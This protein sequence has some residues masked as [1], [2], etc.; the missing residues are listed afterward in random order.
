MND[1]RRRKCEMCRSNRPEPSTLT[2]PKSTTR[3]AKQRT[4]HGTSDEGEDGHERDDEEESELSV[5]KMLNFLESE[6]DTF[7]RMETA[8]C[9]ADTEVVALDAFVEGDS[10]ILII[11][12][13]RFVEVRS[14]SAQGNEARAKQEQTISPK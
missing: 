7:V 11:A 14:V 4:S 3:R 2:E 5:R 12:T 10:I 9:K 8:R 6:D 13:Q 1:A